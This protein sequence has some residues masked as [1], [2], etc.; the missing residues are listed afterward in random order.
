[1]LQVRRIAAIYRRMPR[2]IATAAAAAEPHGRAYL[3]RRMIDLIDWGM[4][5]LAERIN[6]TGVAANT[7]SHL[8]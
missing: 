1:M 2:F 8:M 3:F 5:Q 7:N 4:D 6:R